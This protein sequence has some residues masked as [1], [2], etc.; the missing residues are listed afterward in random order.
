VEDQVYA[1]FD[2]EPLKDQAV[3]LV[4]AVGQGTSVKESLDKLNGYYLKGEISNMYDLAF[5]DEDDTCKASQK[6]QNAINKDR[7]DKWL[8][9]LPQ[10][11]EEKS[12][13]IAV[14]ALHLAGEEG[15]LYQLAKMGYKIQA[16]E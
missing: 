3:A 13:L 10:I 6:A 5:N 16:V 14:G 9:K 8:L 2:A 12:S 15:L 4:C 7:N 1:L 11:M